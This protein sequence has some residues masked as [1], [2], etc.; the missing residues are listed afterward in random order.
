MFTH[1]VRFWRSCKNIHFIELNL[2][3]FAKRAR[4]Q[5]T[6]VYMAIYFQADWY[7]F[8]FDP[9]SGLALW[10]FEAEVRGP[11][12]AILTPADA[13]AGG[14][15]LFLHLLVLIA[16]VVA[17]QTPGQVVPQLGEVVLPAWRALGRRGGCAVRDHVLPRRTFGAEE[18]CSRGRVLVL[19]GRDW[20]LRRR[21]A[22]RKGREQEQQQELWREPVVFFTF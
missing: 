10:V 18:A 17:V 19:V 3:S 8:G 22:Q 1:R 21:T 6:Q 4:L 16:E 5:P 15:A 13:V 12:E 9:Q 14:R 7:T 20:L 11:V 2:G